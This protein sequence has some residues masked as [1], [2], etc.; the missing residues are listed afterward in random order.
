MYIRL[1]LDK[2]INKLV[3]EMSPQYVVRKNPTKLEYTT[4][5][6]QNINI[7]IQT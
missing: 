7:N 1:E 2:I 6:K 5:A 4:I 3:T